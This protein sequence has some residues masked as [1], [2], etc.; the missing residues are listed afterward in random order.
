VRPGQ[1]IRPPSS[2]DDLWGHATLLRSLLHRCS[3]LPGEL[4]TCPAP[5]AGGDRE[6]LPTLLLHRG[7]TSARALPF[8]SS[9]GAPFPPQPA[10]SA[11]R[12]LPMSAVA[13]SSTLPSSST[14]D[15][16]GCAAP[17]GSCS[18]S[19][20]PL[21]ARASVARSGGH[22]G[23]VEL[24]GQLLTAAAAEGVAPHRNAALESASLP[25]SRR[26]PAAACLLCLLCHGRPALLCLLPSDC[27][28]CCGA[29]PR[30]YRCRRE[31][32]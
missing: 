6:L 17:P 27:F 19:S 15:S 30:C 12:V 31:E 23:G 10:L 14:S 24:R 16:R 4:P 29:L 18:L 9:V 22:R 2:V 3:I 26:L 5:C 11:S 32:P 20:D 28:A 25:P 8:I 7:P 21:R 13:E 1:P